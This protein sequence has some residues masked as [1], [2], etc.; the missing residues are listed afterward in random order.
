MSR[1]GEIFSGGDRAEKIQ[2]EHG[3]IFQVPPYEFQFRN[4]P[5]DEARESS[6]RSQGA[7]IGENDRTVVGVAHQIPF[8]KMMSSD[9]QI[10]EMLRLES[11]EAWVSGR[12]PSCQIIIPDQRVRNSQ[13]EWCL[14]RH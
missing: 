4:L 11:G 1:F 5:E 2:L 13:N 9:G 6:V 10:R 8:I 12:D 14:Y 3:L 7:V